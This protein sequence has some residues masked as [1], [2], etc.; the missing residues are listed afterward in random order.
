MALSI[1]GTSRNA[2][3][4]EELVGSAMLQNLPFTRHASFGRLDR[5]EFTET[6]F[7]TFDRARQRRR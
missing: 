2:E 6:T 7:A 3:G 5:S 1:F 4:L